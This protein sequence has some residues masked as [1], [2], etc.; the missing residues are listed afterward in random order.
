VLK[1]YKEHGRVLE[2]IMTGT[3]ISPTDQLRGYLLKRQTK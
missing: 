2:G 1:M 3:P